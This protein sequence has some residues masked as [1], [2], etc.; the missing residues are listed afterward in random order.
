MSND[1]ARSRLGRWL[2]PGGEEPD[3]RFTL[4]NERTFL[5]W[6]RTSLAFIAAG[7]ALEAF[8][9]E[10]FHAGLRRAVSLIVV[11]IGLFIALSAAGRWRR[12]ENSLR[13]HAP[14][15][16]PALLPL[17]ALGTALAAGVVIALVVT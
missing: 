1:D 15:P 4:A 13:H 12:V 10:L 3:P 8:G 16:P 5:A 17:L 7:V 9:D 14:L 11:A 6:I 2:L